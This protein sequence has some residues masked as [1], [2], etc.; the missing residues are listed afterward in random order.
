M[1]KIYTFFFFALFVSAIVAQP[2]DPVTNPC[3]PVTITFFTAKAEKAGVKLEWATESEQN[4]SHFD[5]ERSVDGRGFSR[6]ASIKCE[7]KA[8]YQFV[9]DTP[10]SIGAY[11]RL[12]QVDFDGRREIFKAVFVEQRTGKLTIFPNPTKSNV[13]I[14]SEKEISVVDMTGRVIKKSEP[15]IVVVSDLPK[16]LYIV[17][18][19][20]E[21]SRIIV[22]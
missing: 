6:I 10:L 22:Q 18:S 12:S 14:V 17:K 20:S 9:D 13:T 5:I 8:R 11:Y 15:G 4:A 2:C 3:L 16:G 19:G 7:N 1:K 21:I